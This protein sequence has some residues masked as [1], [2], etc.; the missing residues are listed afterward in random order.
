MDILGPAFRL[1]SGKAWDAGKYPDFPILF[2]GLIF[3]PALFLGVENMGALFALARVVNLALTLLSASLLYFSSKRFLSPAWQSV[4]L[5]LFLACPAVLFAAVYVKVESLILVETLLAFLFAQKSLERPERLRYAAFCGAASALSFAT[6]YNPFPA[7]FFLSALFLAARRSRIPKSGF[8]RPFLVFSFAFLLAA[9]CAWP[10]ILHI[11][12]RR[13]GLVSDLYFS[14]LP[15]PYKAAADFFAFPEGRIAYPLLLILPVGVGFFQSLA[16]AWGLA[17]RSVKKDFSSLVL[18]YF[19][20]YLAAVIGAV[21]IHSPW[22]FTPLAPF[23][24]LAASAALSRLPRRTAPLVAV[25]AL[26]LSLYQAPAVVD[27]VQGVQNAILRAHA[28]ASDARAEKDELMVLV[29]GPLT[30]RA[31]LDAENLD[32]EVRKK[33]PRF[34]LIYEAYVQNFCRYPENPGYLRQCRYLQGLVSEP[35]GYHTVWS[36]R[37]SFPLRSVI[38]FPEAR[39]RFVFLEK[40]A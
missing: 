14:S 11:L 39:A 17:S 13:S 3:R 21:A 20:C 2:Y 27:L 9:V 40:N 26:S 38:P 37:T 23:F 19:F 15:S 25:A 33:S 6:K 35:R 10:G 16:G 8:L 32:A 29:N 30:L 24:A 34:I 12:G 28:D 31:G 36:Q 7:L 1:A 4:C 5:A 18:P 22:L